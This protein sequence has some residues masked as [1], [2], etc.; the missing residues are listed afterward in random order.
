[1]KKKEIIYWLTQYNYKLENDLSYAG[2]ARQLNLNAASVQNRIRTIVCPSAK[3]YTYSFHLDI[4]LKSLRENLALTTAANKYGANKSTLATYFV[5]FDGLEFTVK[6]LA[7]RNLNIKLPDHVMDAHKR[8]LETKEQ[9]P[10]K[11]DEFEGMFNEILIPEPSEKEP[12]IEDEK[13]EIITEPV[14]SQELVSINYIELSTQ[15]GILIK[16][17]E[18]IPDNKVTKLIKIVR[19]M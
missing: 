7:S 12:E 1:M 16:I 6:Y 15:D 8:I 18:S 5:H 19:S 2:L 9:L 4:Y 13:E 10:E 14:K 11:E 17:P 3:K